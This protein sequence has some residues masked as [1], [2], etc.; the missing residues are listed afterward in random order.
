MLLNFA[1]ASAGVMPNK[2]FTL[3][4]LQG[5]ETIYSPKRPHFTVKVVFLL[6]HLGKVQQL[7]SRMG[8]LWS[9][10]VLAEMVSK[11]CTG[12]RILF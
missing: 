12:L 9:W 3:Y 5:L 2:Y 6:L 8:I 4:A 7:V 11:V 1:P 10:S